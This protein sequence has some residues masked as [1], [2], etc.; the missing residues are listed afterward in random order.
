[1]NDTAF[2]LIRT[3]MTPAGLVTVHK[4]SDLLVISGPDGEQHTLSAEL[5]QPE[6][7]QAHLEGFCAHYGG[8]EPQI[9]RGLTSNQMGLLR[10]AADRVEDSITFLS[11]SSVAIT[12]VRVFATAVSCAYQH[13]SGGED[14][15]E[16]LFIHRAHQ[17][18]CDAIESRWNSH[19]P[20]L[21]W[22]DFEA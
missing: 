3:R 7:L 12:D 9:V 22:M 2:F 14:E 21:S 13:I 6:R 10:E 4:S 8:T 20:E 16:S 17:K 11:G 15:A 5:T 19:N 1:M 18:S